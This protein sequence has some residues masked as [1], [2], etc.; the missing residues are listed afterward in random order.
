MKI[1]NIEPVLV[2]VPYMYNG[3]K[4]KGVPIRAMTDILMIRVDTEDGITGWGEAFALRG[5]RVIRQALVEI[6]MPLAIG[7]DA[8][9]IDSFMRGI[10]RTVHNVSRNGPVEFALS[11][12]EIA[13]WDIAAKKAGQPLYRFLGGAETETVPAYASLYRHHVTDIVA[14]DCDAALRQ[15]FKHV[16]LHEHDVPEVRVARETLGPN[17]TLMVDTNCAWGPEEAIRMAKEMRPYNLA[18][19]E[20]PVWPP[21]DYAA[22]KRVRTEGGIAVG[23]GENGGV[24]G[25]QEMMR[26]GVVDFLQPSV[27]K[28][29]GISAML[30]IIALAKELRI[31][32]MPHSPIFGPGL[33]A[34][35]HIIAAM[36]PDSLAELRL[37]DIEASPLGNII[38]AKDGNMRV[39]QGPGLGIEIDPDVVKRYRVA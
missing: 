8:T 3:G 18:W 7:G 39:P 22:I 23:A 16:K 19:L 17:V 10:Q 21:E 13:L 31:P 14:N 29:G 11:G 35:V 30:R 34:S 38:V 37:C 33:V 5:A 2:S 36:L 27:T 4:P 12:L 9:E 28:M 1:V 32:V 26:Q 20:E 15:G 6:V 25:L 24:I